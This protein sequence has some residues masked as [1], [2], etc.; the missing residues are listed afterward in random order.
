LGGGNLNLAVLRRCEEKESAIVGEA[1]RNQGKVKT[2]RRVG[3][4]RG[5]V[6]RGEQIRGQLGEGRGLEKLR[7]WG[8]K[9]AVKKLTCSTPWKK[10]EGRWG[11]KRRTR[12]TGRSETGMKGVTRG[13]KRGRLNNNKRGRES[14]F[15]KKTHVVVGGEKKKKPPK[16]K[17]RERPGFGREAQF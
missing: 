15:P 6:K 8:E 9:S 16:R 3:G 13:E 4:K 7:R 11:K 14:P 1:A 2:K 17:L 12:R 10:Q 5:S